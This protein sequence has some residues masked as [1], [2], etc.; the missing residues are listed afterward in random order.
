MKPFEKCSVC[1]G[2]M[3]NKRVEKL[4]KGGGTLIQMKKPAH[5]LDLANQFSST[6]RFELKVV[7]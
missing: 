4:L 5:I 6:N 7:P 3:E 2:E 1:G